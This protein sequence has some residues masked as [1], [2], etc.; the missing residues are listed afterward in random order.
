MISL[1]H[2]WA[3][4]S[5]SYRNDVWRV[6]RSCARQAFWPSYPLALSMRMWRRKRRLGV[7]SYLWSICQLW[8]RPTARSDRA[9][10]WQM[11]GAAAR[12]CQRLSRLLLA[13]SVRVRYGTSRFQQQPGKWFVCVLWLHD[14]PVCQEAT[15]KTRDG[16]QQTA[17]GLVHHASALSQPSKQGLSQLRWP[18]YSGLRALERLRRVLDR[19]GADLSRWPDNRT[20][21]QQRTLRAGQLYLGAFIRAIKEQTPVIGM[22][23]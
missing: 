17:H 2:A 16:G 19:Y 10:V 8:S 5:R 23:I 7:R 11:D 6:A 20:S 12:S 4:R 13:L 22:G 9:S 14:W 1:M 3:K 21:E 15:D 18:R